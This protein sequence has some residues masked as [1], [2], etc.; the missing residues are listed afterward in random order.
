MKAAQIA[1]LEIHMWES[2]LT[3]EARKRGT[4]TN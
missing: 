4:Q 3:L 2:V 1:L